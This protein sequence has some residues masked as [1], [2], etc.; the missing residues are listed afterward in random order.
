MSSYVY[1]DLT[2]SGTLIAM[3]ADLSHDPEGQAAF[4][5]EFHLTT[6]PAAPAA[7]PPAPA[8]DERTP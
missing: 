3:P 2:G 6:P 5:A 8:A 1:L 4:F 7:D